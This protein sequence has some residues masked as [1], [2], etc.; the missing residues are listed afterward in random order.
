MNK[1]SWA[2]FGSALL[3]GGA[4]ML[5]APGSRG[6]EAQGATPLYLDP[7]RPFEARAA[8]LVSRMTLDEK[9]SQLINDAAAVPRLGVP[10]YN[11]WNECLHG[12]ARAGVGHRVPAGDRPGGVLR[13]R[14]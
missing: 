11:W 2:A 8:D 4:A 9:V 3:L 12:V 14:R 10:A 5:A 7:E 1:R 13:H 6:V